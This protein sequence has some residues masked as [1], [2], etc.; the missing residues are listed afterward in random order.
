MSKKALLTDPVTNFVVLPHFWKFKIENKSC[1][2]LRFGEFL[3][4]DSWPHFLLLKIYYNSKLTSVNLLW[5]FRSATF[6]LAFLVPNYLQQCK[7]HCSKDHKGHKLILAS[8]TSYNFEGQIWPYLPYYLWS[9][10]EFLDFIVQSVFCSKFPQLAR[11]GILNYMMTSADQ[12]VSLLSPM[13]L[14]KFLQLSMKIC[15]SRTY[16]LIVMPTCKHTLGQ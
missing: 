1:L 12:N 6:I 5:S 8:L 15:V 11:N 10:K 9:I 4:Q 13:I 3:S 7:C 16:F 14:F 2:F